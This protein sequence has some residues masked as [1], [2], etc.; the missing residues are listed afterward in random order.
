[1]YVIGSQAI[2]LVNPGAPEELR[3]SSEI[4]MYPGNAKDW[5]L[6]QADPDAEASEL[7]SAVLGFGSAF[8]QRHGFYV[9][10]VDEETAILP[11]DWLDRANSSIV[12]DGDRSIK[13]IAPR[14]EDLIVSKLCRLDEKDRAFIRAFNADDP[15]DLLEI[16]VRLE[17]TSA[18]ESVKKRARRF[19][20]EIRRDHGALPE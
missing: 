20:D 3:R 6:A 10:G 15:L 2:L 11:P 12:R 19:L 8:H 9:D 5:E 7:I 1:V 16:R 13:V 4:D 17:A 14:S 18:A